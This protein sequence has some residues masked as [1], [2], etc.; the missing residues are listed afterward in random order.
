MSPITL[1]DAQHLDQHD[2]LAHFRQRF[3]LLPDKLY[4]DGNSLGL[5]SKE[6]ENSLLRVLEEWKTL[7]INGWMDGNPPWFHQAE[8]LAS[9]QAGLVGA[10]PQEVIV[11]GSTTINQHLLMATFYHPTSHR[12]EILVDELNFPSDHYAVQ[13]FL[14]LKGMDPERHL[15]IVK[16]RDGR[17]LEES[18]IIEAM[19][20]RTA[21]VLLPSVLYRS[22][23]LL[24]MA[25]LTASAHE[26]GSF[27]G[28]D[29]SHSAGAVPH[30]LHDHGVDFAFWCNYKYFNNGPGGSASLF[31]H[32][33]HH[34][35]GPGLAGWF[36]CNKERQFDMDL[37]FHPAS[38]AGAWQLGTPHQLSMAPLEGSLAIVEEAGI[39]NL[40]RKSLA[41]TDFMMRL[42]DEMLADDEFS[43]GTPRDAGRRGGHV[44]LEH[45]EAFRINEAL[46]DRGIIPDFRKPNI[47]RLAP[48]ALYNSYEDIWHLVAALQD[49]MKNRV[50][51]QYD[52]HRG[53]VT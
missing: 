17:T 45:E 4:F 9:R 22:G 36:G 31:V 29:M 14:K 51:E 24:D 18:D 3:Y 1:E 44:A 48:T 20:D 42:I 10:L 19:S 40:R 37:T 46:K 25:F 30:H 43:I 50:Y 21:L 15:R 38:D 33:H 8:K 7:G 5:L 39:E 49:I 52:N 32:E 53:E 16:S 13:S 47:I 12:Y 11:H 28:F 6:A 26:Q 41:M 27:I 2:P 34:G 35:T 23:Q